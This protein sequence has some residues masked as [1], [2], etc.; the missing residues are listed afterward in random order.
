MKLNDSSVLVAVKWIFAF[1]ISFWLGI[2]LMV[3][4][5]VICM[6][7]D[8]ATGLLASFISHSLGSHKGSIGIAKKVL[9]LILVAMAHVITE[10][11]KLPFDLGVVVASAYIVNEVIS[12]TENCANSGVPIPPALLDVLLKAK[13]LT[14]R[15]IKPIAVVE[16]LEQ[17]VITRP[18]G[19]GGTESVVSSKKVTIQG[20]DS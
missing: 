11:L 12:I 19:L 14:G 1:L 2:P 7:L 18:D 13:K 15:G 20:D 10:V 6:G 16:K 3:Q 9:I 8:F 4:T 17:V 5:L